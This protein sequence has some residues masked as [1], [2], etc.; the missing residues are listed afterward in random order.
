MINLNLAKED[1]GLEYEV[2][3]M[4]EKQKHNSYRA[5]IEEIIKKKQVDRNRFQR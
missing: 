3:N 2:F 1:D 4:S 5:D